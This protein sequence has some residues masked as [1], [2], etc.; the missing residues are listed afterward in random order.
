MTY[1]KETKCIEMGNL[2]ASDYKFNKYIYLPRPDDANSEK[3]HNIRGIKR[4]MVYR[5]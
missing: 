1:N 5:S 3:V 4:A 2:R